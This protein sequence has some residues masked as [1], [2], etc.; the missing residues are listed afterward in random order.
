MYTV[1][2]DSETSSSFVFFSHRILNEIECTI[3][4]SHLEKNASM[5]HIWT[6]FDASR[7]NNFLNSISDISSYLARATS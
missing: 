6:V 7:K 4:F 5:L 2:W 3:S 1:L